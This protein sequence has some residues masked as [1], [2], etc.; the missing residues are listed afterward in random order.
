MHQVFFILFAASAATFG[1]AASPF[2][3]NARV[4]SVV[5]GVGFFALLF[6]QVRGV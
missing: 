3:S 6:V 5:T 2:F 4:A 1:L